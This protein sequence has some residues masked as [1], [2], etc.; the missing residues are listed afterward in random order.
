MY[1]YG[2]TSL[3]RRVDDV[4]VNDAGLIDSPIRICGIEKI[5]AV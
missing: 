1:D 3:R 5:E 4:N 2:L